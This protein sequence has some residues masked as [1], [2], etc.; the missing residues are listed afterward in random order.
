MIGGGKKGGWGRAHK[1]L[2]DVRSDF[3]HKLSRA[4]VDRY[5]V[6]AVGGLRIVKTYYRVR[7]VR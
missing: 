1:K 6:V 3:L 7:S 4:Y 2:R 5:D